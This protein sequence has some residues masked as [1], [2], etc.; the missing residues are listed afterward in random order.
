MR[1]KQMH[2]AKYKQLKKVSYIQKNKFKKCLKQ[3]KRRT[4]NCG[5]S[6]ILLPVFILEGI[7][8]DVM[9]EISS[10]AKIEMLNDIN[11]ITEN[12]E[13]IRRRSEFDHS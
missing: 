10:Q 12:K 13:K 3:F 5:N 8:S 11:R 6:S 9:L 1:Q 2:K 7:L 4:N